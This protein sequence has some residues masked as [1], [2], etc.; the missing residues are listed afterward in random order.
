MR[1]TFQIPADFREFMRDVVEQIDGS[2]RGALV[3]NDALQ[4]ECGRGGRVADTDIF[5]FT[6][7]TA[8]GH[9]RWMIG[10]REQEIHE[11]AE[12]RLREIEAD[13]LD[14]NTR[15]SRGEALVVWGEY[16]EDALRG[17][18]LF[19]LGI[20]LD[21]LHS[22]AEVEPCALRLWS[23]SDDQAFAVINGND[24]AIYVVASSDGYGTSVGDPTRSDEFPIVD[25]DAGA[26][27]VGGRDCIPW[28]IARLAL[29]QFAD[30]G[31]LG[32]QVILEGSIS[33]QLL[34]FGDFDRLAELETRRPPTADPAMSSLPA[35]SP[36]GAWAKRLLDSLLELALIEID[37]SI[38]DSVGA[39]LAILLMQHGSEAQ[40]SPE[41]AQ[42]LERG[43]AKLRG[44]GALFATAGDLQI[45]LRRTQDPP[46]MP[47]EVPLS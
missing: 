32:D 1:Q 14:A 19:D 3:G 8:D 38:H 40:D 35:K 9:G 15:T 23:I 13:Q 31:K 12:G 10:L 16:D 33:S 27:T 17:R 11:I 20:V 47:I 46:T 39:R 26:M 34:M 4:H 29:I 7:F 24:C 2:D 44:V 21:G 42:R 45:A 25:H 22:I 36:H 28:R 18:S 30:S 43:L 37:T 6:Y 41:A 5:K